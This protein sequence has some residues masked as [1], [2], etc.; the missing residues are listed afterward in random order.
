MMKINE[1]VL[2][3][4]EKAIFALRSL[5]RSYGYSQYK[6]SKFEE[7]DLYAENK[8]FLVSDNI[9]TFTGA[10]GKLMALKPD[11]TLSIVKST[12]DSDGALNKVYYNENVYRAEKGASDF[13]E[14]MQAGLECIGD[15][16]DYCL[17][18][19]LMLA[20]K[21]LSIISEDF[22]LD[23]SHHGIVADALDRLGLSGIARAQVLSD[24]ADKNLHSAMAVCESE[25]VSKENT[26][27]LRSL[28]TCYGDPQK[29]LD[30]I[31]PQLS[32]SNTSAKELR[33]LIELLG[34]N[35]PQ[36]KIRLDFSVAGDMSY[37]NGLA[38][39]GFI[40][41]IS[42][43][44]LSGGRYDN[45]LR[46]MGRKSNAV[47]F[48]LYLDLLEELEDDIDE[49]DFDA[50]LLYDDKTDI[51]ELKKA[52]DSIALSGKSVKAQKGIPEK[53]RYKT[54]MKIGEKGVEILEEN[55]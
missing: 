24:I 25:G 55:A 42:Q 52:V 4:G 18:E 13:K 20:A 30:E 53:I 22:V 46:K 21:S 12:K 14:I 16:D 3:N 5:Y 9:I 15:I 1:K 44:V 31:E 10:G 35:I 8:S 23:I 37:Y 39:S 41:G 32:K 6:M 7:Y 48:A 49:Y 36:D 26:E 54:L 38:F 34:E 11:V 50:V 29:V 33:R 47:G 45:L 27:L 28:I 43:K 2:K 17:C 19:V 40:Q 51:S